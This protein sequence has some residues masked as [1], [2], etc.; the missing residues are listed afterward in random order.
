MNIEKKMND[1]IGVNNASGS[2]NQIM[3]E[4]TE[5]GMV[6][7]IVNEKYKVMIRDQ[8][9]AFGVRVVGTNNK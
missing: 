9:Q 5:K 1:V 4:W 2:I 8:N 3:N 7:D 6:L